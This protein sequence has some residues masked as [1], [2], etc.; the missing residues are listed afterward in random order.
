MMIAAWSRILW[1]WLH[2]AQQARR[3]RAGEPQLPLV[4]RLRPQR[5]WLRFMI[6]L[7]LVVVVTSAAG[8]AAFATDTAESYWEGI[9]WSISLMTTV[10]WSG[11]PPTTFI[12]H[13]I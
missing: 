7:A 8:L 12:G 3:E 2:I 10:G 6:P 11:A 13:L 4:V 1:T 9:W 5:A